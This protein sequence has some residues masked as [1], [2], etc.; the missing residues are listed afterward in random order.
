ML[1]VVSR[2]TTSLVAS[3]V[4][5]SMVALFAADDQFQLLISTT[6]YIATVVTVITLRTA[7]AIDV[8]TWF[9]FPVVSIEK[10]KR[11]FI[12][13]IFPSS[14]CCNFLYKNKEQEEER[15]ALCSDFLYWGKKAIDQMTTSY[16]LYL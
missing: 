16:F 15:E 6:P 1:A 12:L 2:M 8:V 13:N 3:Q 9:S 7:F 4:Q 11:N 14:Y 10:K 5:K